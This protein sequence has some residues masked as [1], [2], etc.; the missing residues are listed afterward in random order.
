MQLIIKQYLSLLKESQELDK[1]LP[2]LL[3]TMGIEPL[4][5]AQIGVKQYG[6]DIAAVG[7]DELGVPTYFIFTV[8]QG[9]IGRSDWKGNPQKVR[10]S[11]E[12]IQD[13]YIPKFIEEKYKDLPKKIILCTGGDKKQEI[14]LDWASYVDKNTIDGELTFEFWGGDTLAILI[15]KYLFNEAIVPDEFQ[16]SMRKIL[17]LV[18]DPDYDLSDYQ[19]ILNGLLTDKDFGDVSKQST[20]KKILKSLRTISLCQNI[21]FKWAED[22]G[23][24]YP[25]IYCCE[26]TVLHCW[27]FITKYNLT[28]NVSV[29]DVFY[30]IYNTLYIVYVD[31]FNKVQGHCHI[32]D[33]FCGYGNDHIQENLNIFKH[34][35][36]LSTSGLLCLFQ[37]LGSNNFDHFSESISNVIETLKAYIQNHQATNLP[38][39]DEHIIEISETILFL[40][41]LGHKDFVQEWLNRILQHLVFAYKG[42]GRYFP[43]HTDSF[44]DLIGLNISG[45]IEKE[46]LFK[47][48]TLLPTLA[49]WCITLDFDDTY[50]EIRSIVNEVFPEC[51]LQIWYPDSETDEL[52][53]FRNASNTGNMNAQIELLESIEEMINRVQQLERNALGLDDFSAFKNG[54]AILPILASRH[55]RTPFLPV[56]WQQF[57]IKKSRS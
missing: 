23:N 34:L 31:Y 35:G 6:V 9:N 48:S 24:L 40:A 18:G 4:S 39:Y 19:V 1:L 20:Q 21:I 44:D 27:G 11:L 26:R 49:Y 12:D 2:D 8:K 25:A 57:L 45:D 54:F 43:I 33:G 7:N 28:K 36:L 10:E 3:L 29:G 55:F 50:Q 38:V 37:A 47:L 15:E 46:T 32:R 53:Y 5:R 30:E 56:Y 41:S 42:K 22:E 16:A 13:T 51:I 52:L 14:S 17:A